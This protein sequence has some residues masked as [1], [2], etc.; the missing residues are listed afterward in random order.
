MAASTLQKII[1]KNISKLHLKCDFRSIRALSSRYNSQE[2]DDYLYSATNIARLKPSLYRRLKGKPPVLYTVDNID[3]A[4]PV[5]LGEP[6]TAT[7]SGRKIVISAR[8]DRKA[9]GKY[10]KVTQVDPS[11]FWPSP[12]IIQVRY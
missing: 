9:Y 2:D 7:V 8:F 5:Q 4:A 1:E 11:T 10:G 6:L 12:K 3:P